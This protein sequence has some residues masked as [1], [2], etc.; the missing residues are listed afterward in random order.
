MESIK[1]IKENYNTMEPAS[2]IEAYASDERAGVKN[3]VLSMEKRIQALVKEKERM[4]AMLCSR[5][6]WGAAR[7]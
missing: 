2:F 6:V 1:N 4:Y 3:L 7:L 5:S